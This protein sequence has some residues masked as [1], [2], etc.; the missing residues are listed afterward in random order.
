MALKRVAG[1]GKAAA[2]GVVVEG[3]PVERQAGGPGFAEGL[4]EGRVFVG[5]GIPG[6]R[7]QRKRSRA[8]GGGMLF[9]EGREG[10]AGTHFKQKGRAGL[11]ECG[12]TI[13]ESDGVADVA[14]VV[15]GIGGLGSGDEFPREI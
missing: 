2:A 10:G 3:G 6:G 12:N 15:G 1:E 8:G 14:D 13:G 5:S 4:Q 9:G 11:T 7:E